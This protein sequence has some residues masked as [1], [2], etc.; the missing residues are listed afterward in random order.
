MAD[1]DYYEVLGVPRDASEEE[2]KKAYRNLARKYHPDANPGDPQAEERFKKIN[3]AYEVL[4]DPEKRA[5]YDQ[6]GRVQGSQGGSAGYG[7]FGGFGPNPFEDI[8]DMF[9]GMGTPRSRRAPGPEP[10]ADLQVVLE[11]SLEEAAHG[12][13]KVVEVTR[14]E[15]CPACGGFGGEG[16]AKPTTCPVCGGRGQVQ[17]VQQ[18]ALGRFVTVHTCERCGGTGQVISQPCHRCQGTGRVK[19]RRQL[20]VQVPPGVDTGHKLRLSGEGEGGRRGGP[21]GDLYVTIR[22]REHEIFR[23]DHNDLLVTVPV[24]FAQVALGATIEVPSLD[25]PAKLHI[26]A[27]TQ[28]GS[29]FR[30]RGKGMPDVRGYGRGDLVVTVQVRTPT[31][32]TERQKAILQEWAALESEHVDAGERGFFQRVREALGGKE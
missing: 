2:I 16:G 25:G 9:F 11:I 26:P 30:L 17:H 10:G 24:G 19:V 21:A 28:S 29:V 22:V 6:F 4:R 8:F 23:R 27:G 32:L 7:D 18:T 13:A 12:V 14:A 15:T 1:S 3:E 31:T 5:R 20:E